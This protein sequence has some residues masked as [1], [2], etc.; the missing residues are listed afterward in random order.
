MKLVR[1]GAEPEFRMFSTGHSAKNATSTSSTLYYSSPEPGWRLVSAFWVRASL[2]LFAELCSL[3]TCRHLHSIATL[4]QPRLDSCRTPPQD[5][6]LVLQSVPRLPPL[7]G[8]SSGRLDCLLLVL[9]AC[10][11]LCKNLSR[12]FRA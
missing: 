1:G 5:S 7:T 3:R 11:Q 4:D 6:R 10:W 9:G 8:R 12:P 2:T